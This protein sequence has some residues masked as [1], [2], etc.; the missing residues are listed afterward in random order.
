MAA[1]VVRE[2]E[3]VLPKTFPAL[4]ARETPEGAFWRKFRVPVAVK[5]AAS[6]TSIAFSPAA[7]HDY[8]VASGARVGLFDARRNAEARAFTRFKD[9]VYVAAWRGDGRLLAAGTA[10]GA[11]AALDVASKAT[12]RTF[13]GHAGAVRAAGFVRGGGDGALLYS[14][15][16]DAALKLWDV[17]TGACVASRAGAHA[18]YVRA[19]AAPAAG[20]GAL[21]GGAVLATGS[22]DH[23]V[24]LWDVR[25][26]RGADGGASGGGAG[27]EEMDGGAAAGTGDVGSDAGAAEAAADEDE[28]EDDSDDESDGSDDDDDDDGD[29]DA[30]DDAADASAGAAA[31]DAAGFF[32]G[33][34]HAG[35]GGGA[36]F[37][38]GGGGGGGCVLTVD[39]GEPV[40]SVALLRGGAA[41]V[42]TGGTTVKV[43]DVVGGG[44]LLASFSSHA[45]LVAACA[46]DAT[47]ARLLT[48]GLDGVVKVHE[49][50][51]WAVVHTARF[52]GAALLAVAVPPDNSRF[53]VGA[54]D[55]T[56]WVRARALRL[57]DALLERRGAALMRAGSHRYFVRG[58]G[59]AGA[60]AEDA[61]A[62]GAAAAAPAHKPRLRAYEKALKAFAHGAALDAALATGA[63]ATVAALLR[64][65]GA[66]GAL[67][68]AVG[69]R[70]ARA[71]EPLLA[72]LAA[73]V[74]APRYAALVADVADVVADA[75]AGALAR[76]AA[77][78][79]GAL[80]ALLATYFA[81]LVAGARAELALG[82]ALL[83]V[84]GQL[85]AVMAAATAD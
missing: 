35:A 17:A 19:S 33:G 77:G 15:G 54:A 24:R 8:A 22:Y 80:A 5:H 63:P 11:V 71:L 60:R 59:G 50:A 70:D 27:D 52:P 48:A 36:S 72:F 41:L 10:R 12:L 32:A 16:D 64:E 58:A 37:L 39:H 18:D 76:G 9:A 61:G 44:R 47:G 78:D 81:R 82:D 43:W 28:D 25:A 68:A 6:V 49:T 20:G 1:P 69:G 85:D 74:A 55:G 13:S 23:T 7:P 30:E 2:F 84:Q 51:L 57:G 26:L 46:P 40:T 38:G 4:E 73:H 75:Y 21:L 34:A 45:A 3:R 62:G 79:D 66:R 67:S 56:L 42:S 31:A 29:D 83:G 14:S 65:L 53:A